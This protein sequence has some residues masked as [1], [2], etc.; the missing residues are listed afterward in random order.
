MIIGIPERRNF[1]LHLLDLLPVHLRQLLQRRILVCKAIQGIF[2]RLLLLLP[3]VIDIL[4][5][6]VFERRYLRR[7]P[8]V[9]I[10]QLCEHL[11]LALAMLATQT[12]LLLLVTILEVLM[13]AQMLIFDLD[14]F[15]V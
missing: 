6:R 9:Q 2:N 15:R 4:G 13:G 12:L 5:V 11:L 14:L 3:N 8:R 10:L 1:S 7:V